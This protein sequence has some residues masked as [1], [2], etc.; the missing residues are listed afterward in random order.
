MM[1][2]ETLRLIRIIHDLSATE[3]ARQLKI[4]VGQLSKIENGNA[5]PSL[6]L[7]E[8]Y[9]SIFKTTSSVL[10]LFAENLDTEKKRGKIKI[11][12]RDKMFKLLQ[13]L[14]DYKDDKENKKNST[15]TKPAI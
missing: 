14:G 6:E 10:L 3:L 7:I 15:R 2:N 1:I 12:I 9:A 11:S 13:M 4:S 5:T 8:K